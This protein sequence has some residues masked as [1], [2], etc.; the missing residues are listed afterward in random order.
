[1]E[2]NIRKDIEDLMEINIDCASYEY[3]SKKLD[4][5]SAV[6]LK[7]KL[8]VLQKEKEQKD[9]I[10]SI[11]SSD[12]EIDDYLVFQYDMILDEVGLKHTSQ[13][14]GYF[15]SNDSNEYFEC[16]QGYSQNE[17]IKLVFIDGK[18]YKVTITADIGSSKQ[19]RGDRLYWVERIEDVTYE[20]IEKPLEKEREV[21]VYSLSLYEDEISIIEEYFKD[22]SIPYK[23]GR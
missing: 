6:Q 23:K 4:K 9:F 16:G 3:E 5:M 15:K 20:E 8:E 21:I 17:A 1:M 18:Y 14:E 13:I 19:D 22:N 10:D 12:W 2:N 7:Y 11:D